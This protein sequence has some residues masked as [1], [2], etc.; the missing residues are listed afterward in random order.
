MDDLPPPHGQRVRDQAPVAAP[1]LRLS[2]HDGG[3]A[4]ACL[5]LQPLERLTELRRGHVVRVALKGRV[6]PARVRGAR[7]WPT[8][9]AQ[10]ALMPVADLLGSQGLG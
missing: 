1:P 9:A 4:L 6:L 2:A 5:C 7:S 3:G 8:K 10:G